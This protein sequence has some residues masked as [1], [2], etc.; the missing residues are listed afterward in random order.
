MEIVNRT[1]SIPN[2]LFTSEVLAQTATQINL[3]TKFKMR[4]QEFNTL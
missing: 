2:K 3:A 4:T 1:I